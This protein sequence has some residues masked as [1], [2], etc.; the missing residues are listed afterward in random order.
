[1]PSFAGCWDVCIWRDPSEDWSEATKHT[2]YNLLVN[3]I[4][5]IEVYITIFNKERKRFA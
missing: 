2:T 5:H 1:M 4:I 3:V